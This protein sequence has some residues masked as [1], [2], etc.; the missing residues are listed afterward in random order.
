MNPILGPDGVEIKEPLCPEISLSLWNAGHFA[1]LH[2]E[3][4]SEEDMVIS[5]KMV[6]VYLFVSTLAQR[7]AAGDVELVEK[8]DSI[9]KKEYYNSLLRE[10]STNLV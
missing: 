2:R 3:G 4:E 8:G 5:G 9:H 10:I 1:G 6:N 7:I